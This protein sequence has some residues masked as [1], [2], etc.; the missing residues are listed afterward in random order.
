MAAA[1]T[2]L[3]SVGWAVVEMGLTLKLDIKPAAA[4]SWCELVVDNHQI[5]RPGTSCS[6]H[7]CHYYSPRA[8]GVILIYSVLTRTGGGQ[9]TAAQGRQ[10]AAQSLHGI[11]SSWDMAGCACSA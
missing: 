4:P 10:A 11:E 2:L 9:K 5:N 6:R 3:L 7:A 1:K 8:R